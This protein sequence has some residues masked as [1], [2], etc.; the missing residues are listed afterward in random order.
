MR[1]FDGISDRRIEHHA[2]TDQQGGA[3]RHPSSL[4]TYLV[5][6]R[7]VYCQW[8]LLLSVIGTLLL[9]LLTPY[10]KGGLER[11][12]AP[13][14]P[15]SLAKPVRMRISAKVS[16]S[17]VRPMSRLVTKPWSPL[18]C[19]PQIIAIQVCLC[20][21]NPPLAAKDSHGQKIFR[22]GGSVGPATKL[23]R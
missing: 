6:L 20:S 22:C 15:E 10:V 21:R 18:P 19:H 3:E 9:D 13:G 4:A 8:V 16:S 14:P 12:P 5:M 1:I 23:V 11:I 7:T 17:G 2:S